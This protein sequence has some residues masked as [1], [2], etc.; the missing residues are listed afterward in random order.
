[1]QWAPAPGAPAPGGASTAG[2]S[3][4]APAPGA[5]A[6]GRQPTRGASTRGRQHQGA[7]TRGAATSSSRSPSPL[8]YAKH[9]NSKRAHVTIAA[10]LAALYRIALP[11]GCGLQNLQG[12]RYHEKFRHVCTFFN[13]D[14]LIYSSLGSFY[15]PCLVMLVLYY[16]I[17]TV[18]RSRAKKTPDSCRSINGECG[19][20]LRRLSGVFLLCWLP[21]FIT[22]LMWA[23]ACLKNFDHQESLASSANTTGA[24][25]VFIVWLGYVNSFLNPV[26]YTIFNNEFRKAF[27]KLPCTFSDCP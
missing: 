12:L 11:I 26:I 18:I 14:F 17:F 8:K 27:K 15:I 23:P 20:R 16:R 2:A 19:W 5:P 1:H 4:G 3:T 22:N 7:S 24:S 10:H 25:N 6:P 21:F 13:G 9:R